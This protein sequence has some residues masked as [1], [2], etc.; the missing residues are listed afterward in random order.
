MFHVWVGGLVKVLRRECNPNRRGAGSLSK[1]K[2]PAFI[3]KGTVRGN[4][5]SSSWEGG[6]PDHSRWG[7]KAWGDTILWSDYVTGRRGKSAGTPGVSG[8]GRRDD[9]K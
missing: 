7:G 5:S 4:S 1:V 2:K 6:G 3:L 9:H 8:L